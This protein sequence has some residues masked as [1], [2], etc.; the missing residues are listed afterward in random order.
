MRLTSLAAVVCV[1]LSA[2]FFA[3]GASA[4]TSTYTETVLHSFCAQTG[5][6]DGEQPAVGLMQA[7][8]GNFYG[9]TSG[10][11]D[12]SGSCTGCGTVFR[13][14]PSGEFATVY[15]FC[16]LANCADGV[17]P[18]GGLIEGGDG[19][20]YGTTM[21]GGTGPGGDGTVFRLTFAGVLTTLANFSIASGPELP[22]S[23]LVQGSDGNFY[24]TTPYGGALSDECSGCGTVF[25]LTPS[26][27]LT[28]LYAF[29][30]G[31]VEGC[32]EG[33]NPTARLVQGTDGEFY[34][35]TPDSTLG[36][37]TIFKITSAGDLTTL[38]DPA[39]EG[40]SGLVE[41][42]NGQFY[43]ADSG[44][45]FEVNSN[46]T[47]SN[48]AN[49]YSS[50]DPFLASDGKFYDTGDDQPYGAIFQVTASGTV[51]II[52]DLGNNGPTAGVIQGADGAL[53][54]VTEGGGASN[55]G[56]IYKISA[57]PALA[58]PVQVSLS[59]AS[60]AIG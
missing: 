22:M 59:E 14:S 30:S 38:V 52:Y 54:G 29:C 16:R 47:L 45:F 56:T 24:G 32:Y 4:Q 25:Q 31:E 37:A 1:L 39:Q 2:L 36:S 8:D 33:E 35:T 12:Q 19:N 3:P 13:I 18:M 53:Y 5:C 60:I 11:Y 28:Q 57:S 26:G 17:I 7:S 15:T 43:G 9:V 46:G 41:G 23:A 50:S 55:E 58:G 20:L 27:V 48:L 21:D 42:S 40:P 34:G 44:S 10:R 51:T 6:P 49:F